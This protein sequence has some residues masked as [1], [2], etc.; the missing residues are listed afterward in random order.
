VSVILLGGAR[1]AVNNIEPSILTISNSRVRSLSLSPSLLLHYNWR[2]NHP[3]CSA[4]TH[5]APLALSPVEKRNHVYST[6]LA[7]AVSAVHADGCKMIHRESGRCARSESIFS[8]L[9]SVIYGIERIMMQALG[10]Q[11][12]FPPDCGWLIEYVPVRTK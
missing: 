2:I 1:R 8:S 10:M 3:L 9:G 7:Q 12:L 5:H 4:R 6:L 11:R